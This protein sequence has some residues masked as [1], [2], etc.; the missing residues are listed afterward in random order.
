VSWQSPHDGTLIANEL[1]SLMT[2]TADF[3][4]AV[5]SF[6][7]GAFVGNLT[8]YGAHPNNFCE[9]EG[10]PSEQQTSIA[11][12]VRAGASAAHGTV[13]E[14]YNH[15]FPNAGLLM[16]L[17][18]GYSYGEA[19]LYNQQ[20]LYWKNLYLGDPLMAPWAERPV[21][22]APE[23]W[24]VGQAVELVASHGEGIAEWRIFVDGVRVQT[25]P[26]SEPF[27]SPSGQVGD[28]QALLIVAVAEDV[29]LEGFPVQP[30]VQ[31]W[32]SGS[33]T[34]EEPQTMDTADSG[35]PVPPEGCGGCGGSGS[36]LWILAL[37]ALRGLRRR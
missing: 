6:E 9:G 13:D 26:G 30:G 37:L 36:G 35:S 7:P 5:L 21:V 27:F 15:C 1:A 3:K 34:L 25:L 20:F 16:M 18:S 23:S 31:G 4:S 33:M 10:C 17:V 29:D 22:S 12:F 14:P 19:A 28:T 11:R 24:P 32:W 2:G 8:S